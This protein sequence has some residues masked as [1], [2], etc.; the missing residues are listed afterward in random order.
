MPA[1]TFAGMII[2][3]GIVG[4]D[5]GTDS[6]GAGARYLGIGSAENSVEI[7]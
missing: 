3:G 5:H 6:G 1:L 4:Y 7:Q 2:T